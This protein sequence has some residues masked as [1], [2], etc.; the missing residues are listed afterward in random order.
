MM[1]LS[2]RSIWFVAIALSAL[3]LGSTGWSWSRATRLQRVQIERLDRLTRHS[4]TISDL[5]T[6][7]PAWAL[8]AKPAGALAPEISATLTGSGLP[9]SAMSSL[10]A[11]PGTATQ[12]G[13]AQ[14]SVQARTRRATLVLASLTLPQ[15]GTFCETWRQRQPA[16]TIAALDISPELGAPTAKAQTGGDLPLRAVLTLETIS[17]E[18]S[19]GVR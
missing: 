4:K 18:R 17:L 7:L 5:S 11:D 14:A 9:A 15:L 10:A 16:W 8:G 13:P 12:P 3:T 2:P 19:G 1:G 6:G